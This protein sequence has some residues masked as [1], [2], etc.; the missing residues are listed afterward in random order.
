MIT[1]YRID[2][3]IEVLDKIRKEQGHNMIAADS[4]IEFSTGY[5]DGES[6]LSEYDFIEVPDTEKEK[7]KPI[8]YIGK[9]KE[10]T[11]G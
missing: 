10:W 5:T 4:E 2:N 7:Y 1:L 6:Y 3:L 8:H 9:P 11:Y